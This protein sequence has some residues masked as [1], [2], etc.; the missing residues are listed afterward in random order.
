MLKPIAPAHELLK[1]SPSFA[2]AYQH[3]IDHPDAFWAQIAT[4]IRWMSPFKTVQNVSFTT[5]V[6]I[7]WF[8][9]GTLNVSDNCLDR[10][11]E[12]LRDKTALIFVPDEPGPNVHITYGQLHEQ[13]C[14]FA[15]LLKS[16]KVKKG[17]RVTLYLPMSVEAVVAMLACTR[18]GAIHSVVF[19]GFAPEALAGRIQGCGSSVLITA[20]VSYR[21]GKTIDLKSQADEALN[22]APSATTCLMFKRNAASTPALKEGRDYAVDLTQL[23]AHSAYCP[24]EPMNAEAPLFILYTSGSTGAP[25]GIVH[26]TGGYLV[27]A[28]FTHDT[29]FD[30]KPDDIYFCTADVGWITGH[31]YVV[32]GPLANGSTVVIFEGVPTYPTASR[33]WDIIDELGVTLFYTA[34]T[35]IRA[36]MSQGDEFLESSHR[37]S[38]RI[39]GSVGEPINPA[40]WEWY[41]QKVG[42]RQCPIAD[43]WWQTETGGFMLCPLPAT[44]DPKP[45]AVMHPCLG[46]DPVL[47]NADQTVVASE[48]TGHLCIKNSWPGQARTLYGHHDKFEDVYFKPFPGYYYSGDGC[49]RDADGDL[50]ITGRMDDVINVSGHRLSTAEIENALV[51]HFD[52]AEAAVVG[53]PHPIKGEGI[54]AYVTLKMHSASSPDLLKTLKAQVRKIIGPIAT[55]D[56]IHITPGLPKTRSGKIMRRILRKIAAGQVEDFGDLSTLAD[57]SVVEKLTQERLTLT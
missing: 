1:T 7:K 25:K 8:E 10:H 37:K 11:L 52:V 19:A 44:K 53:F 55:P 9:E 23:Q 54:Y 22:M 14:R 39:L 20:D 40:A 6:S 49:I 30:L 4:R 34:P 45:G 18:I 46:I 36:L 42:N 43:T 17:D 57:P 12:T 38:L 41:Y 27:Y 3:S 35:A 32:Y 21:S 16:H 13:V 5:P 56:L 28:A 2:Q 51:G 33:Y 48:G 47:L 15:N 24:P 31:S 29:I 50:W 26:T